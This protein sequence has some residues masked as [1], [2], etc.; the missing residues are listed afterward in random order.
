M[1]NATSQQKSRKSLDHIIN[2]IAAYY[3]RSQNFQDMTKLSDLEYCDKLVILTSKIINKYLDETSIKYLAQKKGIMGEQIVRSNIL[4]INK[5]E[6][7]KMDEK[8]TTKKRRMCIGLAKHYVQVANLFAAIASTIN[9]EYNFKDASGNITTVGL[10]NRDEAPKDH[11]P[12]ITKNNLCSK[13][14]AALLNNQDFLML[15]NQFKEGNIKI[16]PEFC[17]INCDDCPSI[18]NLAQEPGIPELQTL[19]YDK[20]NYDTGEFS[21]MT[22]EMENLYKNDVH[23][24]YKIFTN[25][26]SVPETVTKFSDIK[27]KDYYETIGCEDGSYTKPVEGSSTNYLFYA[28]VSNIKKMIASIKNNH[29]Q[30]LDILDALFIFGINPETKYTA[31]IIN[32]NLTDTLLLKLTQKTIKIINNLYTSCEKRFTKGIEI[33]TSIAQKQLLKT[34]KSQI[35]NLNKLKTTFDQ[36]ISDQ[37]ISDQ[38]ISDQP[39]SDQPISDLLYP[40]NLYPIYLYPIY[41]YPIYLYPI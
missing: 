8:N 33:Y 10:E 21:K 41:L 12:K 32:P 25:N 29:D 28:Y 7:D 23:E 38:P 16:N 40:I 22:K 11:I 17:T 1:G 35:N 19:Y 26:E 31:V 4:A 36:P 20:Y 13:R 15:E 27:L 24:M 6:L 5:D 37:P 30:L 18:K 14:V 3:I 2:Y 34:T 39:I 9:P